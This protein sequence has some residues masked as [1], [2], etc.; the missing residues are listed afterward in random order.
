MSTNSNVESSPSSTNASSKT[1]TAP[2]KSVNDNVPPSPSPSP[3]VAPIPSIPI[4]PTTSAILRIQT[5]NHLI[6]GSL[7]PPPPPPHHHPSTLNT[8]CSDPILIR[9]STIISQLNEI[10][11][12][13]GKPL[14]LL[15]D[16]WEI[17]SSLL[18]PISPCSPIKCTTTTT[19]DIAQQASYILSQEQEL[20]SYL[21]DLES[22]QTLIH[23]HAVLNSDNN[24]NLARKSHQHPLPPT[25]C[26]LSSLLLCSKM[27]TSLTPPLPTPKHFGFAT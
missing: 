16:N 26:S 20:K 21:Q 2:L 7:P 15:L 13:S 9:I 24:R 11:Q 4:S 25:T 12:M 27:F 22:I 1:D 18:D 14:N 3:V 17:Y 6:Y 5:L 19:W 8:S 23:H 10:K